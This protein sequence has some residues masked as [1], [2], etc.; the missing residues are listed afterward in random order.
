M[1]HASL[2][3]REGVNQQVVQ[4][5]LGH[6]SIAITSD[7][8]SHLFPGMQE[9]AADKFDRALAGSIPNNAAASVRESLP[10]T[11]R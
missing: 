5:R 7:I 11:D 10:L 9:E 4:E 3:L 2:L 6:S 8:Y 1:T